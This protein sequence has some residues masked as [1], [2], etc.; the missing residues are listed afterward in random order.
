MNL[1][2]FS[3]RGFDRG[4]PAVVEWAWLLV[5]AV[6][7]NS[8][9]PFNFSRIA[10][11]RLFGARLGEGVIVKP[12]VKVKFPWRLVVGEHS[13]IGEDVWIDN[14]A[15]VTIGAQS[16]VS[17]G[18]YLCTGNH[19]WRKESFDLMTAPITVGREVWVGAR[20]V[21]GPGVS[22]GDGSI[23]TLGAVVTQD[24]SPGSVFRP[25]GARHAHA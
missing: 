15:C 8:V 1:A 25:A 24:L 6:A 12:G 22:I 10:A 18:A 3:S 2:Q 14:L 21:V 4:R 16:C 11:L 17:Q 9:N 23:V 13:W 20:A 7:F 19:D 5:R